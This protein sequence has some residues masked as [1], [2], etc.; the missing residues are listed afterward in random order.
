MEENNKLT[1]N[2]NEH[3]KP[4]EDIQLDIETVTP[5]TEAA[6]VEKENKNAQTTD[7]QKQNNNSDQEVKDDGSQ[8]KDNHAGTEED[9]SQKQQGSPE[10]PTNDNIDHEQDEVKDE[11]SQSDQQKGPDDDIETVS[12]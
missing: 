12:P 10:E 2:S 11:A 7:D 5:D 3:P 4:T 1:N 8:K 9:T 6:K